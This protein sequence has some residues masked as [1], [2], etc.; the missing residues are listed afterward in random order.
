MVGYL[1][2]LVLALVLTIIIEA[3]VSW[4][5]GLRGKKGL[6]SVALVNVITNPVL[7]YIVLLNS[8]FHLVDR[9]DVLIIILEAGVVLAEWVLLRWA[10]RQAAVKMFVLSLVMN[11]ASF[12][13]GLFILGTF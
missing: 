7:N 2:Q 9:A 12:L 4:I 10:L 5:F 13:A 6:G 11:A 3:G 8:F 1:A